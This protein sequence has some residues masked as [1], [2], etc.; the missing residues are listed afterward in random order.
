MDQNLDQLHS[1]IGLSAGD[2]E[3][4]TYPNT[5]KQDFLTVGEMACESG[6]T[7]RAF[8]LYENKGLLSPRRQGSARLYGP[9]DRR[10]L[11]LVLK[12][13][14]LGFTLA[15]IRQMLGDEQPGF[16]AL[17][18]TRRQCFDQIK[19]L[20]QRKPE[21]ETALAELRRTYSSFYARIASSVV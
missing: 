16:A 6:A 18:I 10:R 12:A 3:L 14:G 8:R 5:A 11:A 4:P 7:P 20:E 13:K 15:E 19:L 2:G 1:S 21:I 17:S 9:A